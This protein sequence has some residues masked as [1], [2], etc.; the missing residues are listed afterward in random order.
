MKKFMCHYSLPFFVKGDVVYDE[1]LH[2]L[3]VVTHVMHNPTLPIFK[4]I[5]SEY[6]TD[7]MYV[8]REMPLAYSVVTK[9][10]QYVCKNSNF[11]RCINRYK[12]YHRYP[13]SPVG[14]F[15]RNFAFVS[16]CQK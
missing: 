7:N 9:S 4:A 13:D 12:V 6:Y 8:N 1:N 5:A 16:S 2:L 15:L 3:L 14:N 10:L 11:T